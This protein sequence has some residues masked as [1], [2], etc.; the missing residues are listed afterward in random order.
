M[1]LSKMV[2]NLLRTQ[3]I[4]L[5]LF[6]KGFG[7]LL[8]RMGLAHYLKAERPE[9]QEGEARSRDVRSTAVRFREAL[10]ELGGAFVKLGQLL[11]TRPDILPRAWI[12]E[13]S[14]PF[15]KYGV[16]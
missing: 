6:R 1:P 7:D 16:V 3:E 2:G 9:D 14:T 8:E 4:L 10:E 5:V 13:L 15:H 12:E 11:S